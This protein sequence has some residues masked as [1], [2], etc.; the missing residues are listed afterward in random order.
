M[1]DMV[2]MEGIGVVVVMAEV[3][4]DS[5]AAMEVVEAAVEVVTVEEAA[6][7]AEVVKGAFA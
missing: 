1:V 2:G 6:E 3:A 4:A 7:G 5:S